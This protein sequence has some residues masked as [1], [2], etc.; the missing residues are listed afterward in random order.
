MH[1]TDKD[2]NNKLITFRVAQGMEGDMDKRIDEGDYD[3]R[4]EI[5][6]KAVKRLLKRET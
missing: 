4:S 5:I 3:N 2:K 1:D 6:R